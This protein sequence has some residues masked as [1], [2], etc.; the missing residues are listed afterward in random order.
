MSL[1]KR[2]LIANRGEIACRIIKTAKRYIPI[3]LEWASKL[4]QSTVTSTGIQSSLI[5]PIVHTELD[6]TLLVTQI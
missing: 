5:W 2:I 6:L 3:H 4:S 1:V